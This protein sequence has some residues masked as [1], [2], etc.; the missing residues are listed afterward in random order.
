MSVVL[1]VIPDVIVE[2]V[3]VITAI[4]PGGP[5]DSDAVS[6]TSY[7]IV[8]VGDNLTDHDGNKLIFNG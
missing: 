1:S 6:G 4:Q 7:W 3:R 5:S 8:G 2:P